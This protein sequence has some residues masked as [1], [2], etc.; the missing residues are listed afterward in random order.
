MLNPFPYIT[1]NTLYEKTIIVLISVKKREKR[2]LYLL[3][4]NIEYKNVESYVIF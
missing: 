1:Q 4:P 2:S 3:D